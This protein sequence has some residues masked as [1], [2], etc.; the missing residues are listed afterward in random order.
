MTVCPA[1]NPEGGIYYY[2][3]IP[4]FSGPLS[5]DNCALD[6]IYAALPRLSDHYLSPYV[7]LE[8]LAPPQWAIYYFY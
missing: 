6:A 2:C 3:F 1:S 7:S 4:L 5:Y 8:L